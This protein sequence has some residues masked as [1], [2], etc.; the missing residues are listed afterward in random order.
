MRIAA[1]SA[2]AANCEP[3]LNMVVPNLIEAGVPDAEIRKAV[4][5]GQ[6]VKDRKADIMKEAA[7]VLAGTSLLDKEVPE[8]CTPR[9]M[10]LIRA[11]KTSMLIAVGAAVAGNCESCLSTL[12]PEVKNAGATDEEIRGAVKVGETV[13]E[14]PAAIVSQAAD[15]LLGAGGSDRPATDEHAPMGDQQRG[16]GCGQ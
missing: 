11:D 13:K 1:A 4:E 5:I 14:R 6:C 8:G 2:M 15:E 7:D 10:E 12:V 9:E 16:C 3:C